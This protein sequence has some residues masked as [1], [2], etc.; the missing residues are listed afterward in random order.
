M[1]EFSSQT[2]VSEGECGG[3]EGCP[4]NGAAFRSPSADDSAQ[5]SFAFPTDAI[6]SDELEAVR[7]LFA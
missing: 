6:A 7:R 1:F 4:G 2:D 3:G 5:T